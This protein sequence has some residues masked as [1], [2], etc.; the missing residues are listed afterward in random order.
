MVNA[1]GGAEWKN[2]KTANTVR[3]P[4]KAAT[5]TATRR[6]RPNSSVIGAGSQREADLFLSTGSIGAY[7]IAFFVD[8]DL[9]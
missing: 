2:Q 3:A 6:S 9:V 5:M 8:V 4:E 7:Q 1:F